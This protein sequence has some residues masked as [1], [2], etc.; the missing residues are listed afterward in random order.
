MSIRVYPGA[1]NPTHD[2]SLSDGVQTWGLRLDG[3]PEALKE[4]P[5]TP[6]TLRTSGASGFGAWEP[7]LAE[8]E[9]RDWSGG[10][11]Q[12][13]FSA[14]DASLARSFYDSQSAWT[15]TPGLL[16]PAPQWRL[17]R[18]LRPAVQ[19][20]PGSVK[21][22]GL[23]GQSACISARFSLGTQPLAAAGARVWL[24]RI[25]SPQ[26]LFL[27]LYEDEGGQPAAA[28]AD[29][30]SSVSLAEISDVVSVFHTFSLDGLSAEL[31]AG[32]DY[33][34]VLRAS[35]QDN[36]A[37]HWE[38]GVDPKG[39]GGHSSPEGETWTP[40]RFSPYFRLEDAP[41]KRNFLFCSY[42]GALYAVDQRADGSPS[43]VYL[44]GGRGLASGWSATTLE[45]A[46][47][48]WE[49]DQWA[50]A[51]VRLI[52]GRGAGQ[53]RQIV[54]NGVNQLNVDAWEQQPDASSEYV[55]YASD[56]WQDLTPASGD[57]IDGV[58]LAVAVLNDQVFLAQGADVPILRMRFNTALSTPAHEF[59]DDGANVADLLCVG[60]IPG[61]G[62][63]LY[64]GLAAAAQVARAAPA[65]WGTALSFGALIQVGDYSRPLRALLQHQGQVW[66]L[67]A[68]GLW[69]LDGNDEAQPAG[70]AL[71]ALPAGTEVLPWQPGATKCGWAGEHACCTFPAASSATWVPPFPSALAPSPPCSRWKR[72]AWPWPSTRATRGGPVCCCGRPAPGTNCCAPR[73]R[74]SASKA[75][76]CSVIPAPARACG[77]FWTGIWPMSTCRATQLLRWAMRAWPTSTKPCW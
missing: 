8:L 15:L 19:Q 17:G 18:G 46:D 49:P 61:L 65:N 24:R 56:I 58:V 42:R 11:G 41:L 71:Q 4:Q 69:T 5:L 7:G 66:V 12:P 32:L 2:I 43:H 53:A 76:R 9:Q 45:D 54:S 29:S 10:G 33:H 62:P 13:R 31:E 77:W 73:K 47:Q 67:K 21:W 30:G 28:V 38:L 25:G 64:R 52:A 36:A 40:A 34:L 20:L 16:L 63:Q 55:I 74:A 39:A 57:L 22:Q 59:E 37:N 14:E 27:A 44:N 48:G 72:A 6:S 50:G 75:W 3:G 26:A 35:A 1:S 51:W 68:D 23:L 60:S 70:L